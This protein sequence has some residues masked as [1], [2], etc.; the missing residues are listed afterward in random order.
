MDL[1]QLV[2]F[3]WQGQPT[4]TLK[5]SV[6]ERLG[7]TVAGRGRTHSSVDRHR[8]VLLAG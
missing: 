3:M 6:G 8:S 5:T 2:S 4:A 1:C 7:I